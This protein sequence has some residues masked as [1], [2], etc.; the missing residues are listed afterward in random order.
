MIIHLLFKE[1]SSFVRVDWYV[2]AYTRLSIISF[3]STFLWAILPPWLG[4]VSESSFVRLKVLIFVSSA[5]APLPDPVVS[6]CSPCMILYIRFFRTEL[7][8]RL[9]CLGRRCVLV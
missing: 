9:P 4:C 8:I 6:L 2:Y 1:S 3:H 7:A 5:A